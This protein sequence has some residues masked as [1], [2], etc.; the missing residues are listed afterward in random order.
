ML[1]NKRFLRFLG[2]ATSATTIA[3]TMSAC[4]ADPSIAPTLAETDPFLVHRWQALGASVV[5]G[6]LQLILVVFISNGNPSEEFI[7]RSVVG[8]LFFGPLGFSKL[9]EWWYYLV[10]SVGNFWSPLIQS[11]GVITG[12]SGSTSAII[13][14]ITVFGFVLTNPSLFYLII[15]PSLVGLVI[16]LILLIAIKFFASSQKTQ[17]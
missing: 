2:I 4:A 1:S 5:L 15:P 13:F 9:G 14:Q 17:D 8:G 16:H 10:Q 3:L 7:P 11:W 6:F 12:L